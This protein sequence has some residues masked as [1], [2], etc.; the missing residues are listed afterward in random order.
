MVCAN[1]GDVCHFSAAHTCPT[2]EPFSTRH[3]TLSNF[4]LWLLFRQGTKS[5]LSPL[6]GCLRSSVFLAKLSECPVINPLLPLSCFRKS[7][8]SPGQTTRRG[9]VYND[10]RNSQSGGRGRTKITPSAG[11]A[12][13]LAWE[14]PPSTGLDGSKMVTSPHWEASTLGA[15]PALQ[16]ASATRPQAGCVQSQRT[17]SHPKK[18]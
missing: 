13:S 6:S 14:G 3:G 10:V 4:L 1:G 2:V 7:P 9:S 17:G 12:R 15:S 5:V 11:S 8:L 16:T 18:L